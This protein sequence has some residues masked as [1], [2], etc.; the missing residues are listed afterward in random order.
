MPNAFSA[1]I[2]SFAGAHTVSKLPFDGSADQILGHCYPKRSGAA[3]G[4]RAAIRK[5]FEPER[6]QAMMRR[7]IAGAYD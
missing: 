3:L 2:D 6:R 7:R 4:V 5:I 1:L